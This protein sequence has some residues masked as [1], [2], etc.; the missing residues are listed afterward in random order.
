MENQTE[1]V[2]ILPPDVQALANNVADEKKEVVISV[3]NTVFS[4]T[5]EW[6]KQVDSIEVKD[7]NDKVSINMAD[8]IRKAAKDERLVF[9]KMFD[10]KREEVQQ[11]MLS[12]KTEDSLWLKAKQ[13]M[14]ILTK[15]VEEIAKY[16]ADY[17]K[18]Y[19]AEQKELKTQQRMIDVAKFNTEIERV[20]FEN[21]SDETFSKFLSGLEKDYNDRIEAEKKAEEERLEAER[22]EKER[23]AKLEA[24]AE[25]LRKEAIEKEKALEKERKENARLA[26]IEAE[27]QAEIQAELKAK[28]DAE[29]KALEEKARIEKEKADK[30]AAELKAKQ[31]AEIKAQQEKEKAEKEAAEAAKKAAKAPDKEKLMSWVASIKPTINIQLKS[32]EATELCDEIISK[33]AGFQKWAKSEIEKL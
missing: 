18:R 33:F 25:R 26:K 15:E 20:E 31:D 4:K 2:V 30:I 9:E 22:L 6:K 13:T 1:L 14:Q 11:Q 5:S 10:A 3:L 21:M 7:I 32:K 8:V 23:I 27:K 24:D 12:Y 19:E 28:A 16:K 29:R 17:V